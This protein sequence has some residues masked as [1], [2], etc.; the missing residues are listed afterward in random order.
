MKNGTSKREV[1]L[2]NEPIK[3]EPK[4]FSW[5]R[6]AEDNITPLG[7]DVVAK[8]TDIVKLV[9]AHFKVVEISMEE[10]L[11]EVFLAIIHKN[12]GGSAHDPRKSSFGHYVW[13]V[14]N[15]VCINIVH[16]QKRFSLEKDSLDAPYSSDDKRTL[17]DTI[18]VENNHDQ[19]QER[20]E[21]V[22]NAM[23]KKGMWDLARYVRAIR[24]GASPDIIREALSFGDKNVTLKVVRDFRSRVKAFAN[25][26]AKDI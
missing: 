11:Q 6:M 3:K 1:R 8:R 20:L 23:R 24:S 14:A 26:E 15:N 16:K 7:V 22:E 13:M 5:P 17:A 21:E 2:S 12:H 10:L 9:Y 18:E 4:R 19:M 25:T